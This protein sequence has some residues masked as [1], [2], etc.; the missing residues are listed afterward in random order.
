MSRSLSYF[1]SLLLGLV[2]LLA[3]GLAG[4]GLFQVGQSQKL[5]GKTFDLRVGFPQIHGVEEG[6]RVRVQGMDA[7]EV[8][9]IE[10]PQRPGETVVLRLRLDQKFR[11][12]IRTDASAQIVSEGMLGG[13][14]IE[15]DPGSVD[16][17]AVPDDALIVSRR[18]VELA[19][20]LNQTDEIL[21]KVRKGEGTLGKLIHDDSAHAELVHFL[22]QGRGT[23]VSVKQNVDAIKEMPLVRSY[24]QDPQKLMVRPNCE[25]NRWCFAEADLFEP[26]QAVLKEQG[27]KKLDEVAPKVN[28]LKHPGSEVV[29]AAYADPGRDPDYSQTLTQQQSKAVCDYLKKKHRV[30]DMGWWGWSTRPVTPFGCGVNPPPAPEKEQLPAARIEVLVFVPQG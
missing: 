7:G 12:L 6:A 15:V 22:K 28:G 4:W 9:E 17:A 14:V 25:R 26:G 2:V 29:V 8:K 5:W 23:M 20:I 21:S 24:V 19:T 13:K 3:V 1:Q 11:D 27:R 16:A 30:E 10:R 18:T